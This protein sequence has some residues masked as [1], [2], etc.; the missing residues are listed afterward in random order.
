MNNFQST[1]DF[2]NQKTNKIPYKIISFLDILTNK[3][4]INNYP[5]D[6]F[7]SPND[8][9]KDSNNSIFY[10]EYNGYNDENVVNEEKKIKLNWFR[11]YNNSREIKKQL[12]NGFLIYYEKGHLYINDIFNDT[13]RGPIPCGDIYSICE[14]KKG[15]ILVINNKMIL[16]NLR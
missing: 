7:I 2:S 4:F 12:S 1:N 14:L 5:F 10:I 13:I 6:S 9:S 8:K 3:D 15:K 11:T 16:S